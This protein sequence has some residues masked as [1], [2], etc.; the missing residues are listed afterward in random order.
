LGQAAAGTTRSSWDRFE[1]W[2]KLRY[3]KLLNSVRQSQH[4]AEHSPAR[5]I[6]GGAAAILILL[7]IGNAGRIGRMLRARSLRTH[8]ERSP[9]LAAAMWYERMA[10]SLARSGLK[11]SVAQ[12]PQEFV[13]IISPAPLRESVGRFTEAYESARFGNSAD[14]AKRLPELYDEVELTRK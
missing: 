12:T 5:W 6:A 10:Q 3:A 7:L 2:A 14:D 1:S 8:P 13:Q 4:N 11:K 9:D